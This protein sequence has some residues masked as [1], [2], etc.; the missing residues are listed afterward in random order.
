MFRHAAIRTSVLISVM[1][2][3]A[4]PVM[5]QQEE[6]YLTGQTRVFNVADELK[7]SKE[8]ENMPQGS[9]QVDIYGDGAVIIEN[10]KVVETEKPAIAVEP[11]VADETVVIEEPAAE[12]AEAEAEEAA[13]VPAPVEAVVPAVKKSPTQSARERIYENIRRNRGGQ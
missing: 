4:V 7:R 6:S 12:E 3:Y 10:G 2:A 9:T 13:P 11:P 1:G 8:A 5:A